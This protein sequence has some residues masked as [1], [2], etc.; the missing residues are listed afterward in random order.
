MT[1]SKKIQLNLGNSLSKRLYPISLG[2]SLLIS[3]CFPATYYFLEYKGGE[4][5]ASYYAKITADKFQ[6]VIIASPDLWK[7]QIYTFAEI[8]RE[9]AQ[10]SAVL[11][12]HLYDAKG[13]LIPDYGYRNQADEA[14]KWWN[15]WAPKGDANILFNNENVG[16]VEIVTSQKA[17][18]FKTA[19]LFFISASV[20]LLLAFLSY[21]FPVRVVRKL[22]TELQELFSNIQ[23][24]HKESDRLK[25]EAQGSE[26]RFR[27][28]VDGLDA[29]VWEADADT[30]Q[31]CFISR[32]V[33]NLFLFS[34][35]EWLGATDF[36]K[37]Q[38]FPEDC[39]KVLEAY[40]RA[41]E[42]ETDCQLEYRRVAKD[43]S[44][45]WVRDNIRIINIDSEKKQLRGVIVDVTNK[46]HAEEALNKVNRELN[47]SIQQ[48]EQRNWE[49]SALH[50]MSEMLQLC[51]DSE[52]A[53]RII[54]V[55]VI[56]LF[57]EASGAFYILDSSQNTLGLSCSFGKPVEH[58]LHFPPDSCWALRRGNAAWKTAGANQVCKNK[59]C[60]NTHQSFCIPMLSQGDIIGVFHLNLNFVE[61][62][63][64]ETKNDYEAEY[65]L[66][67]SMTEHVALAIANLSLRETLRDLSIRDPLTSLFNRRYLEETL[68]RELVMAER[69]KRTVG[70]IMIDIDHFKNFNDMHGHDAGDTLLREFG[71]FLLHNIRE[72]DIACRYGGE[73]FICILP[74]TTL[75]KAL[76]RAE[77]IR[78]NALSFKVEHLGRPLE[79]VTI[80]AGV[81]IYPEHGTTEA[82]IVKAADE[83]LY[84]AKGE[85]RNRVVAAVV[86]GIKDTKAEL[87][88]VI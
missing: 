14:K 22:E 65:L 6:E 32:Q 50:E 7:Y 1:Y 18:L 33:E 20:G 68:V 42:L 87:Y 54:G 27:D 88:G 11:S 51:R 72:Y 31:F 81:A 21:N 25:H 79:R 45:I 46:R 12:V 84:R 73:E 10:D 63:S 4:N 29:I 38:I 83:A 66:A 15:R 26:K 76:E 24:A 41:I 62:H 48:L 74:E 52:E 59:G 67:V 3:L 44:I 75:E 77:K 9:I 86:A 85:G 57:P 80:S 55:A 61:D 78:I 37:D 34:T 70:I 13:V 16:R 82:T 40:Q 64:N 23:E 30:R 5:T 47:Q 56:K 43:G 39:D 8:R 60:E 19:L 71:S 49:I 69:M 36:F 2:I 53:Y 58:E 17:I 35:S 28:L